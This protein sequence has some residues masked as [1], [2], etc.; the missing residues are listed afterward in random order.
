[1]EDVKQAADAVCDAVVS[2]VAAV[3]NAWDNLDPGL[4]QWIINGAAFAISFIPIAGPL[5]SC[6]IDGTFVDMWNAIQRG[7]WASLALSCAAFVPGMKQAKTGF[8]LLGHADDVAKAS[9]KAAKAGVG[10]ANKKVAVI[11]ETQARIDAY[12]ARYG[13]ETM[14]KLPPGNRMAQ[15][16]VWINSKM[17]EGY[18]IVDIG[19]DPSRSERGAYYAMELHEILVSRNYQRYYPVPGGF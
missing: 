13:G 3:Q 5:I 16:R 12:A 7:D 4:K 9:K 15:N 8:K 10:A 17:D 18:V 1:M 6:I 14:P 2:G 19:M 11:G